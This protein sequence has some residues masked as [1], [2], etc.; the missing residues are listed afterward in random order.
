MA[1]YIIFSDIKYLVETTVRLAGGSSDKE[2]VVEI[3]YNGLWGALCS[4]S[5]DLKEAMVVCRQ[6]GFAEATWGRLEEIYRA[7]ASVSWKTNVTCRGAEDTLFSCSYEK[8]I[9]GKCRKRA[10]VKC[11][12]GNK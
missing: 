2:G 4:N 10:S 11:Y 9:I 7:R 1:I 3:N 8:I 6:L 5:W 12:S